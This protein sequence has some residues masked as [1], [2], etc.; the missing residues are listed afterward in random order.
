MNSNSKT[1]PSFRNVALFP[2]KPALKPLSSWKKQNNTYS[3]HFSLKID[4]KNLTVDI[5]NFVIRTKEEK[6]D[7][8]P[9]DHRYLNKE[10]FAFNTKVIKE[11]MGTFTRSGKN[12]ITFVKK[13][14][15]NKLTFSEHPKFNLYLESSVRGLKVEDCLDSPSYRPQ[16]LQV[17]NIGFKDILSKIGLLEFGRNRQF[18]D[19][20]QEVSLT[21]E[22]IRLK[23][24]KGFK[25]AI[26]IYQG[27][28]RLLVDCSTR[29]IQQDNLWSII[30]NKLKGNTNMDQI[31][32]DMIEGRS[33]ITLHGNQKVVR[34]DELGAKN[35]NG[36]SPFPDK[37]YKSYVDYFM[38]KYQLPNLDPRQPLLAKKVYQEI[39]DKETKETKEVVTLNYFLPQLLQPVGLTDELRANFRVM[40][41][42]SEH[43]IISPANRFGSLQRLLEKVNGL[44]NKSFPVC[45][46]SQEK[47][48]TSYQL[49]AP[50]LIFGNGASDKPTGSRININSIADTN[51]L[52]NW[53][54]IYDSNSSEN[55]DLILA[56]LQKSGKKFRLNVKNPVVEIKL[57]KKPKAEDIWNQIKKESPKNNLPTSVL[58][59]FTR[60]NG[61]TTYKE[62]K[63][64]FNSIGVFTQFFVSFNQRKDTQSLSK[65]ANIALQMVAKSGNKLWKIECDLKETLIVGA[66]VYHCKGAKSVASLTSQFG[67]NLSN[68]FSTSSIQRREYQEVISS[69]SQMI[70]KHIS[71]Y[72][73]V[74]K[75]NPKR[76]VF[77]R[78]GVG[79]SFIEKI[80]EKE[81]KKIIELLD[82]KIGKERPLLTV[83]LVTKRIDD[84]FANKS[85]NNLINPDNGLLVAD[86]V[87]KLNRAS[88]FLIAQKVT[89]GTANPSNYEIIYDENS[90][91][92]GV[93][94]KLTHDLT[95]NYF[96]W[97]GPVKVPSPVQYAHKLCSLVGD[98]QQDKVKENLQS[99]GYYL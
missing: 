91:D 81:I 64:Y 28:L 69:V 72:F 56:N 95:W 18:Y 10:V 32:S 45:V 24:M 2:Q 43:T 52:S 68:S 9:D 89:Q 67:N 34:I 31:C 82:D 36:G 4:A 38:K 30:Q 74:E 7:V 92:L 6:G 47:P 44:K 96:N 97:Q 22:G 21:S 35:L 29:V 50:R 5:W 14:D 70:L 54:L 76:I 90:F 48:I 55:I 84:R 78:D 85:N 17:L 79:E 25:S 3:N 66:D 98:I 23:I 27:G 99:T 53:A 58:F 59:V 49:P 41:D 86:T 62:T 63:R 37:T 40:K 33:F 83:L 87:T 15:E 88:F 42:L 11:T 12:V 1:K 57:T 94:S 26:D 93:L 65:F 77:Y 46:E 20:K 13:I 19:R 61:A 73:K 60:R 51:E 16:M 75:K 8:I 39:Y 71:N 80:L